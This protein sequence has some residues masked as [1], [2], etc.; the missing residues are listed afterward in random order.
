[1]EVW[2]SIEPK[3]PRWFILI[4]AQLIMLGGGSR[5]S[6]HLR[7]YNH[8]HLHHHQILGLGFGLR[9]YSTK[10]VQLSSFIARPLPSFAIGDNHHRLQQRIVSSSTLQCKHPGEIPILPDCFRLV[11]F[12]SQISCFS[13]LK[14]IRIRFFIVWSMRK[15]K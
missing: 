1:M 9:L 5:L 14:N 13:R 4:P 2:F 11:L 6:H 12:C 3:I 15:I 10:I 8:Y 7:D